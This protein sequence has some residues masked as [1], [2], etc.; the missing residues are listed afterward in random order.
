MK[1]ELK[2]SIVVP[3]YNNEKV[4]ES[5][6]NS[7]VSQTYK[8]LEIILVNDGSTDNSKCICED[9]KSKDNRIILINKE[10]GGLSSARNAGIDI[11]TGKYISF[12]DSDDYIINDFYEYLISILEKNNFPDIVQAS[13][14]RI[15]VEKIKYT[16]EILENEN[17]ILEEKVQTLSN[18]EALEKLYG[19]SLEEYVDFVVVWN[20]L[21]KMNLFDNI[22][23]P[24]G[25]LH[26]DE[27]TTYKL[28]YNSKKIIKSNKKIYG[29]IQTSNSI[30]RTSIS[31]KRIDDT[32]DAYENVYSFFEKENQVIL[33]AK[34][35]RRYLEY[36]IELIEKIEKEEKNIENKLKVE[37][38]SKKFKIFYDSNI[39]FI[40][41]NTFDEEEFKIIEKIK[42][43]SAI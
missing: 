42:R 21:Y 26:E 17:R 10:N 31:Q 11:A 1:K 6:L 27:Y 34:A 2:I 16:N 3:I 32:L 28:L 38:L 35:K 15:N 33:M 23:F 19:P 40:I 7:I 20:K 39:D 43:F 30:M 25:R 4:L 37:Y 18:I 12:I 22:R 14:S 8:N 13:F 9:F 24:I 41:K 5:C 36:C 29:Y